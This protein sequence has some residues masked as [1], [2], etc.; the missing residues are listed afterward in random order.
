[1]RISD[2]S[3]DVCSS[4]LIAEEYR[5]VKRELI[6]NFGGVGNRPILPRGHRVLIASANPGEGKTFSAVNLAL[7]LAVEADHDVLLID[8]DI[9]K[10]SI[11]PMLGLDEGPGLMDALADPPL[12]LG[13]CLRAE[14]RRVGKECVSTC[15]SRWSPYL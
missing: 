7:S 11:L 2:W 1:M 8:A 3:S 14:E 12:P 5:I 9:A 10:P 4:D 13:A 6:R 15:R